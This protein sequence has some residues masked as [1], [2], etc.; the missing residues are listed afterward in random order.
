MLI[1]GWC[2]NPC[3]GYLTVQ[4]LINMISYAMRTTSSSVVIKNI[5]RIDMMWLKTF[6]ESVHIY[7]FKDLI[8]KESNSKR[9]KITHWIFLSDFTISQDFNFQ[10]NS[11]F[12]KRKRSVVK[13]VASRIVFNEKVFSKASRGVIFHKRGHSRLDDRDSKIS[14]GSHVSVLLSSALFTKKRS[15]GDVGGVWDEWW[16]EKVRV[17]DRNESGAEDVRFVA[18]KKPTGIEKK[19]YFPRV[20]APLSAAC[21]RRRSLFCVSF[22]MDPPPRLKTTY[23]LGRS[24]EKSWEREFRIEFTRANNVLDGSIFDRSFLPDA[25][26]DVILLTY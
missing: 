17:N 12:R 6:F 2:M 20:P 7:E 19:A 22:S 8:L 10:W 24:W 21:H 15:V 3:K 16:E 23:P 14:R 11:L 1:V 13:R 4:Q 26:S 25:H 5:L 9:G 18:S